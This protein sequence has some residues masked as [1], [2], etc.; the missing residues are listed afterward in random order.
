MKKHILTLII[1]T[2]FVPTVT[3]QI[4]VARYKNSIPPKQ[5][6][7]LLYLFPDILDLIGNPDTLF[8][9]HLPRS[10]SLDTDNPAA[11]NLIVYKRKGVWMGTT[12]QTYAKKNEM[13]YLL[14][15]TIFLL[16]MDWIFERM[17]DELN[18]LDVNHSDR[19]I[20]HSSFFIKNGDEYYW[21]V[22]GT[23]PDFIDTLPDLSNFV[24]VCLFKTYT[25]K[26]IKKYSRKR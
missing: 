16:D 13:E 3:A 23:F 12:L 20:D 17:F 6:F 18:L 15:D 9:C 22:I 21:Y 7:F 24:S 19:T 4:C 14:T 25:S 8:M 2:F 11:I 26:I 10:I 5:N 1:A